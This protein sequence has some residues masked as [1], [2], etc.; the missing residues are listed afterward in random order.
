MSAVR[1]SKLQ[2]STSRPL[3]AL[4]VF[5]PGHFG[6]P[7][8]IVEHEEKIRQLEQETADKKKSM[9]AD[10]Q[11][12]LGERQ[13]K[14]KTQQ[15]KPVGGELS[16]KFVVATVAAATAPVATSSDLNTTNDEDVLVLIDPV[17][18][19]PIE[20]ATSTKLTSQHR[21]I[22]EDSMG[23]TFLLLEE[24][25]SANDSAANPPVPEKGHDKDEQQNYKHG[26]A[27][28]SSPH[29]GGWE[30]R[31]TPRTATRELL[32]IDLE[33]WLLRGCSQDILDRV[34]RRSTPNSP[35]NMEYIDAVVAEHSSSSN[36]LHRSLD[37]GSTRSQATTLPCHD[38]RP[39]SGGKVKSKSL[40]FSSK[41]MH[42]FVRPKSGGPMRSI[43]RSSQHSSASVWGTPWGPIG[44]GRRGRDG[45]G[46][47]VPVDPLRSVNKQPQ[48]YSPV[49]NRLMARVEVETLYR[50]ISTL[51]SANMHLQAE[52]R[53]L[54]GHIEHQQK[55]RRSENA[56]LIEQLEESV[57]VG[58]VLRGQLVSA[59]TQL[60]ATCCVQEDNRNEASLGSQEADSAESQRLRAS[61]ADV[62][63]DNRRLSEETQNMAARM[64]RLERQN[65]ELSTAL[66][67]STLICQTCLKG[68]RTRGDHVEAVDQTVAAPAPRSG[69]PAS[70]A[71][72]VRTGAPKREAVVDVTATTASNV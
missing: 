41:P 23:D 1:K 59:Q 42:G 36:S 39:A 72:R 28:I 47:D 67:S 70:V 4:L 56:A 60:V 21:L 22:C 45:Q 52:T 63:A 12:K 35:P 31:G 16:A 14:K 27:G 3:W 58:C 62:M 24:Q 44:V 7:S 57:S 53:A 9:D 15:C 29:R 11:R 2:L 13:R 68:T 38:S 5:M 32:N 26:S 65:S 20:D 54:V 64:Q 6:A 17:R 46:I 51:Q 8:V 37:S 18:D 43:V 48:G 69:S 71:R 40:Q 55:E 61:L 30:G 50:E 10:L 25:P 19:F 34:Q 49:I 33:T 66:A